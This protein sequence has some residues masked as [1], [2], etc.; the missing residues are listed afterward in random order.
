MLYNVCLTFGYRVHVKLQVYLYFF[1]EPYLLLTSHFAREITVE[2]MFLIEI[3]QVQFFSRGYL[4]IRPKRKHHVVTFKII[5]H[6]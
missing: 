5:I 2:M 6:K 4:Q 1:S 3:S